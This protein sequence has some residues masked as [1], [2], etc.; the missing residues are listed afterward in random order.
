MNFQGFGGYPLSVFIITSVLGDFT[1]ID[2]RIEVCSKSLVMISGIT[3]YYIQVLNFIEIMFGSICRINATYPG[4]NPQPKIAVR[5][6]SL[7][8]S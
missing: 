3:I 2:F 7:K 5:P 8:R 6:A 1:D 4:S